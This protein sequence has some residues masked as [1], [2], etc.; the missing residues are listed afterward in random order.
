MNLDTLDDCMIVR[1]R[2]G[3]LQLGLES[4]KGKWMKV[5][6]FKPEQLGHIADLITIK[7]LENVRKK[8]DS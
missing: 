7:N 3:E 6:D 4:F 1:I 2:D 8:L 5:E